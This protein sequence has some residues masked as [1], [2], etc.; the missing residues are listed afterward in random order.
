MTELEKDI[1]NLRSGLKSVESVSHKDLCDNNVIYWSGC[2]T[3]FS[4]ALLQLFIFP[5][6]FPSPGSF[7]PIGAGIPEE[8]AAG[9]GR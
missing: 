4:A 7:S 6:Q 3:M 1:G 9:A 8:A 5:S 2:C